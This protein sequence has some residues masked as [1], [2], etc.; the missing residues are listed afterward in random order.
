ML[1]EFKIK[2]TVDVRRLKHQL[3]ENLNPKLEDPNNEEEVTLASLM[4]E[5]YYE[6]KIINPNNVSVH[7]AF[8]CMLHLANEKELKFETR[9]DGINSDFKI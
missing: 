4:D 6:K 2:K 3:W 5:L 9:E 7:S 1:N 8:I